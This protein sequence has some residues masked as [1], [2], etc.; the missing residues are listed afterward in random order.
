MLY[1]FRE[2]TVANALP[3]DHAYWRIA[4]EERGEGACSRIFTAG[5]VT[6]QLAWRALAGW[7]GR[8]T[9]T[10]SGIFIRPGADIRGLK[11]HR[12]A[13]TAK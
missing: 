8:S 10:V 6:V 7:R 11:E 13:F 9:G 12:V 4:T 1:A 5:P 2:F 3:I